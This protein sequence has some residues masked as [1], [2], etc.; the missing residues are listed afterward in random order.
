MSWDSAFFWNAFTTRPLV[1]NGKA[2]TT[3][4]V[5]TFYPTIDGTSSSSPIFSMID[6]YQITVLRNTSSATEVPSGALKEISSDLKSVTVNAIT[7]DTLIVVGPTVIFVPDGTE[8]CLLLVGRQ[9]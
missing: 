7:G 6:F 3:S 5:A 1:W 4:G 2:T 8:V 9:T